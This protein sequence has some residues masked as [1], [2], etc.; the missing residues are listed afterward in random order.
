MYEKKSD[1]G[2][3]NVPDLYLT[4]PGTKEIIATFTAIKDYQEKWN[5]KWKIKITDALI[6]PQELEILTSKNVTFD[7]Y[8]RNYWRSRKTGADEPICYMLSNAYLNKFK[9]SKITPE[10]EPSIYEYEFISNEKILLP[11]NGSP[12][13]SLFDSKIIWPDENYYKT[14][15]IK[16]KQHKIK[17]L[18]EEIA[19]LSP[20]NK[21]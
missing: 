17:Q 6:S 3:R 13:Y 7:I 12:L 1:Y 20:D 14:L 15:S 9:S 19:K 21:N 4:K 16:K 8:Y 11:I 10:G 18:S 2:C 5:K